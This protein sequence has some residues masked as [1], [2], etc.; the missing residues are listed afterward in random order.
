M[1][2]GYTPKAKLGS[3]ARF[4]SVQDNVAKGYVKKG[5]SLDQAEKI[6]GAVAAKIGRKKFGSKKMASM[7]ATGKTKSAPES[8]PSAQN[9]F[10]GLKKKK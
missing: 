5:V 9:A 3:G 7:A 2:L 6:G 8:L 4:N 1:K 10:Q